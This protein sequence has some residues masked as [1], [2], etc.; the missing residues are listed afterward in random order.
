LTII[1][2]G[3][4]IQDDKLYYNVEVLLGKE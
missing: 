2:S 4:C 1:Y 3:M